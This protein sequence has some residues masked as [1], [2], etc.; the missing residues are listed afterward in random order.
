MARAGAG[1]IASGLLA[2]A[3]TK[4]MAVM[5]GAPAV[6]IFETLQQ[7]RQIALLAA[8]ANGQ[9]ALLLGASS[10]RGV[11]RREYLRSV[12][13]LF[14]LALGLVATFMCIWRERIG[15][16]A[17]LAPGSGALVAILAIGVACSSSF[18][19]AGALLNAAG[20]IGRLAILQVLATATIAA[21]AGPAVLATRRGFAAAF[22]VLLVI[23]GVAPAVAAWRMLRGDLWFAGT[24]RW[25]TARAV[26]HFFSVSG[27]MLTTGLI[28]SLVLLAV[29]ARITH[30]AGLAAT[31]LFDAAWAI[32]MGQTGLMLAALQTGYLPQLARAGSVEQR[33][34]CIATVFRVAI[35]VAAPVI[36]GLIV[37][38]AMALGILYATAFRAASTVLRWTL[39]GD[40]FKITAWVLAMPML[41]RADMWMLLATD[42]LV[43]AV[44][45]GASGMLSWRRQTGAAQSAAIGFALSYAVC[46]GLGWWYAVR[47]HGFR[48]TRRLG[49]LWIA[50]FTMVALAAG[51]TWRDES[52]SLPELLARIGH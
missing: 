23:S 20:K 29:R 51:S 8:T 2:L 44:F 40:Y 36:A 14:A 34:R 39:V 9:T 22:A 25:L 32:S 4:V 35:L 52:V 28:S 38:R 21:G 46:L 11:E 16:A 42:A 47:R 5:L 31:G 15:R 24:G 17:G 1:S 45:F 3:A 41:A 13:C 50:G 12:L 48:M 49:A 26:K 18:V 7:I 6:A 27:V 19:F 30:Q 10:L 33:S 37:F 43:Q